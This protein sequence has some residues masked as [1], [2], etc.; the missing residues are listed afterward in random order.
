[1]FYHLTFAASTHTGPGGLRQRALMRPVPTIGIG[2]VIGL[3]I[4]FLLN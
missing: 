2:A 1:M 4:F 3:V